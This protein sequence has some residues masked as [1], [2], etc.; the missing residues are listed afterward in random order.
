MEFYRIH[1]ILTYFCYRVKNCQNTEK[2]IKLQG[3]C[4]NKS[5]NMQKSYFAVFFGLPAARK[6]SLFIGFF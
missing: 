4:E 3:K 5:F 1:R 2:D 6:M